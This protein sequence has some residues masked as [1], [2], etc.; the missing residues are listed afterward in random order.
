MPGRQIDYVLTDP[1]VAD[2][3][4]GFRRYIRRPGWEQMW[5]VPGWLG[6]EI[7]IDGSIQLYTATGSEKYNH[8]KTNL[9]VLFGLIGLCL[10]CAGSL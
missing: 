9:V 10:F 7:K 1:S 3:W 4:P 6:E 5:R 8:P 2:C